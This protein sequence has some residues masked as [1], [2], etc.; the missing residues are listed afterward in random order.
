M[1][2]FFPDGI[3]IPV[4]HGVPE[5]SPAGM[6]TVSPLE[7]AVMQADTSSSEQSTAVH[8]GL[9]PVQA[10]STFPHIKNPLR[11]NVQNI[12][13]LKYFFILLLNVL[14]NKNVFSF[15]LYAL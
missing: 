8:V 14:L 13:C 1:V 10:A 12:N 11:K 2:M 15:L 6:V 4:V 7:A 3:V 9:D 5:Q